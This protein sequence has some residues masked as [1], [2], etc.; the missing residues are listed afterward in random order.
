MEFASVD[1]GKGKIR[2][3]VPIAPLKVVD[4]TNKTGTSVTFF[5][6]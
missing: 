1:D 2:S 6:R 3:G 4:S 5:A